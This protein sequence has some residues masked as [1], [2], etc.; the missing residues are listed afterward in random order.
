MAST[1]HQQQQ[2]SQPSHGHQGSLADTIRNTI[3]RMSMDLSSGG[4]NR[5]SRSMPHH[6]HDFHDLGSDDVDDEAMMDDDDDS[7][8]EN[9]HSSSAAKI[10][11]HAQTMPGM[12]SAKENYDSSRDRD[13]SYKSSQPTQL[14]FSAP[15]LTPL[16]LDGYREQTRVRLLSPQLAEEIRHLLPLRL[17][18]YDTWRLCYSLEQHGV[19]LTT[20][21]NL[22]VPPRGTSRPGYVLIV[23]DKHGGIF[24]AYLNEYPHP[25][26][27]GRYY[28]NGECFLWK[29]KVIPNTPL[30]STTSLS[31]TASIRSVNMQFKAFPYTG[32]NDYMILCDPGFISV[33]GGDGKYGIYIDDRFEK[34]ISNS[35]PAFGNEPLS[36]SGMKFDIVGVEIWRISN[37]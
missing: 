17:Q 29:S 12:T 28:G 37:K 27:N 6:H 15:P 3:R 16:T 34:G 9:H 8:N 36:D 25:T 11:H 14:S 31:D 24:G 10:V 23:E 1:S 19:S 35:C 7:H 21:Y 2:S 32:I 18:L 22:C 4:S 26:K 20:L 30:A 5:T 33:G 13:V